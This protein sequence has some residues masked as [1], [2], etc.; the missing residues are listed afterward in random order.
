LPG[1]ITDKDHHNID[2]DNKQLFS[3]STQIS[4]CAKSDSNIDDVAKDGET[5]HKD[6]L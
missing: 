1:T 6:F 4:A 5:G 2:A 3:P